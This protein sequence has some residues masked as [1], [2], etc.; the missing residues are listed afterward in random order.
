M[1]PTDKSPLNDDELRSRLSPEQY[2][3]CMCSATEAPFTGK[4]WD[5]KDDGTYTCTCCNTPLFT[6]DSKFDSGTGWPSFSDS[7]KPEAIGF[8]EDRS[9][10]MA[11]VEIVCNHCGSHLGHVFDDGPPPTG[12]RYC[13]N[14]ASLELVGE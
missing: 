11:R 10:G 7:V 6:S 14:S 3:V 8:R 9:Q 1:Q 13:V 5:C 12:K 2:Q 4:Y